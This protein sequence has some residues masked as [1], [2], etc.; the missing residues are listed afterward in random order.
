MI[1]CLDVHY[2]HDVANAAAIVFADWTS[3]SSPAQYTATVSVPAEYEPGR[4]YLRELPPLLRV[5]EKIREHIDT[6]VIDGYCHLSSDMAPGLGAHLKESV[7][8]AAT[9]I[10]VAK[11]RYRE[12]GH[13]L[14]LLRGESKRP[15]FITA[16]GMDCAMAARHVASMAGDSRIPT[17]LH[18]V[19]RLSRGGR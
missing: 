17:L 5:I 3:P 9:I 13:A 2:D 10:G 14:E 19:D 12:S 6:Y 16:I 11:N 7:A 1:A 4:F 18:A 15:L 8:P